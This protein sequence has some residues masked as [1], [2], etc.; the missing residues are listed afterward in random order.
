MIQDEKLNDSYGASIS[1][2][3]AAELDPTDYMIRTNLAANLINIEDYKG[4][5]DECDIALEINDRDQDAW[6]L[7]GYAHY[8][9]GQD[10]DAKKA[11]KK[12]I[13]LGPET[14]AGLEAKMTLESIE[15][16]TISGQNNTTI[17]I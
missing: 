4:A 8:Y 11:L 6:Y 9:L 7:K 2:R 14:D 3:K 17:Q 16:N 13:D 5:I 15:S 1:Y 10:E 12:A